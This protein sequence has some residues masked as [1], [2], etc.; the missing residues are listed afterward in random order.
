MTTKSTKTEAPAAGLPWHARAQFLRGR[1][2]KQRQAQYRAQVNFLAVILVVTVVAAGLFIYSNWLQAGSTK[3]A[4]CADYPQYCVPYAGGATG[5]DALTR[6]EAP[7]VRTLDGASSAADGVVRGVNN[8]MMPVLGDPSAPIHFALF[9]DYACPHCQ[10]Y[11]AGDL[12]RFIDDYV[13]TGQATMA[14]ALLTGTGGQYSQTGSTAALCA[15]EQGAFWEYSDEMFRLAESMGASSAFDLSQLRD[16]A[17]DMGLDWEAMRACIASGRYNAIL[18]NYTTVALDAGV[19]G[20]P[21]VLFRTS[22]DEP[23][24]QLG[25]DYANL[26]SLTEQANNQ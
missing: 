22:P 26:A 24:K 21:S 11:H 18:Q 4:S 23:W 14:I 16:S 6:L 15:G 7:G 12:R 3:L 13:L 1:T 19:T 20:T 25:R 5:S 8:D 10:D 2:R 9:S 17:R